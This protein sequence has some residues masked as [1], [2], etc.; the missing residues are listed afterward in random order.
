MDKQFKQKMVRKA[1][2]VIEAYKEA[3]RTNDGKEY[4]QLFGKFA[5]ECEAHRIDPE[6]FLPEKKFTSLDFS[7]AI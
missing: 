5:D 6:V 3:L 4:F 1:H 2:Q 7:F